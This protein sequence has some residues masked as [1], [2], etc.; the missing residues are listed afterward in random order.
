MSRP[1]NNSVLETRY[2]SPLDALRWLLALSGGAMTTALA[3]ALECWIESSS[4]S[5]LTIIGL[6]AWGIVPIGAFLLGI[7]AAAGYWAGARWTGTRMTKKFVVVV[8]AIAIAA[9]FTMHYIEFRAAEPLAAGGPGAIRLFLEYYDRTTRSIQFQSFHVHLRNPSAGEGMGLFGYVFRAMEIAV[10]AFGA[11]ITPLMLR[12]VKYCNQCKRYQ[13]RRRLASVSGV[14]DQVLSSLSAS[15]RSGDAEPIRRFIGRAK[16]NGNLV[17][18]YDV[19][20]SR[21]SECGQGVFQVDK[22]YRSGRDSTRRVELASIPVDSEFVR[23]I[24]C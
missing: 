15:A 6:Y 5:E 23:S 2:T 10:F 21:C 20:L 3:L 8:V 13:S 22:I 18:R 12:E 16:V 9:H 7:G 17:N 24:T 11:L 4:H 19:I 14:S 1:V